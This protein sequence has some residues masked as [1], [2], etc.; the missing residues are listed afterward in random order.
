MS[1]TTRRQWLSVGANRRERRA[2]ASGRRPQRR[3]LRLE[4]LEDRRVLATFVVDLATDQDNGNTAAGDVSLRE[5]IV[6]ANTTPGP[7]TI[8]FAAGLSGQTLLLSGSSLPVTEALVIDGS[9]LAER[10]TIDAQSI[11]RVLDIGAGAGDVTL[12]NVALVN[13]R[14]ADATSSAEAGGSGGAVRSLS[15]GTLLLD[16]VSINGS[17][18]GDGYNVPY[19]PYTYGDGSDGGSGGAVFSVGNVV[20]TG[21]TI[22]GNRAG[23]GGEADSFYY[24]AGGVGGDGG[25]VFATGDVTI[26]SSSITGNTAGNG[27]ADPD[28]YGPTS[29]GDGGGV[30][31]GGTV[32]VTD[33]TI[34]GNAAGD[35]GNGPYAGDGGSGGAINAS[36]LLTVTRSTVAD[37]RAGDGGSRPEVLAGVA[38]GDG[39]DG[40]GLV[41]RAGLTM[42]D[43]TVSGN[44]SGHG[45]EADG[46]N[47]SGSGGDG[48]G[49]HVAGALDITQS[50]ISGNATGDGATLRNYSSGY[51][52]SYTNTA[53]GG[54][55][56]GGVFATSVGIIRQSTITGNSV[57]DGGAFY[58]T[59]GYAGPRGDGA[60]AAF[61][62]LSAAGTIEGTI[63]AGN[64]I[65]AG[66]KNLLA[67]D[68]FGE[69]NLIGPGDLPTPP[70]G[71]FNFPFTLTSNDPQIGP[72]K[73]NGGP[74]R[75]HSPL[76]GSPAIDAGDF[77]LVAPPTPLD[78]RGAGFPRLRG[79]VIDIGAVESAG[80]LVNDLGDADDGDAGNGVTTL[81][82]AIN[83]ANATSGF[84][85]IRFDDALLGETITLGSELQIT[86]SVEIDSRR[87]AAGVVT[88]DAAGSGRV[89]NIDDPT[90]TN[91]SFDVVLDD[92]IVTGGQTTGDNELVV[93]VGFET[94]H[95]GGAIRFMSSGTLSLQ[96]T[97]VTQSGT[98]GRNADGGGVFSATGTVE[99]LGGAITGNS[100]LGDGADGGGVYSGGDFVIGGE[101]GL[102]E[103]NSTA[104]VSADGGGVFSLTGKV[105]LGSALLRN[106]TTT[107][108]DSFG[109]GTFSYSGDITAIGSLITGNRTT[110]DGSWGGGVFSELGRVEIRDSTVSGNSTAGGGAYGGAIRT[111]FGDIVITGST[112]SGNTTTGAGAS[113][114]AIHTTAGSVQIVGSTIAENSVQGSGAVGGGVVMLGSGFSS[115]DSAESLAVSNT[116]VAK[117][118]A[119]GA[120]SDVEIA[121]GFST[122]VLY[123]LIGN[124]EGLTL[125]VGSVGGTTATPLD[126]RL[127]P[128]EDNG[129]PFLTHRPLIGS[130]LVDAG[131]PATFA[132]GGDQR[133]D[134]FPRVTDGDGDLAE[135]IDIGAVEAIGLVNPSFEAG[136]GSLAPWQLVNSGAATTTRA[137]SGVASAG[138][139]NNGQGFSV[140]LQNVPINGGETLLF[141]TQYLVAS[142]QP[143]DPAAVGEIKVEFYDAA[144]GFFQGPNF[145]GEVVAPTFDASTPTD[146][147]FYAEL[148]AAAPAEAV[149]ARVVVT[150]VGSDPGAVFY[151]SLALREALVVDSVADV[152]IADDGQTTLREAITL[153][154]TLPGRDAIAF[155]PNLSGQ[156]I[157]LAGS[158]ISITDSL[159]IA[160]D[161]VEAPV[162]IDAQQQSRVFSINDGD[163]AATI[164]VAI[165]DL[166]LTGGATNNQSGGAINTLENLTIERSVI[167]GN[168]TSGFGF[169]GGVFA[170][171]IGTLTVR[172]S[173][174]SGNTAYSGGALI[175]Y[176]TG[177]G[178]VVIESSTLSGNE[179]FGYTGGAIFNQSVLTIT[180]STI[181]DNIGDVGGIFSRFND[182]VNLSN[183]IIAGNRR[184]DGTPTNLANTGTLTG[185]QRFNVI[186]PG[187][188]M[189]MIDGV[190]GNQL[191]VADPLLGPL[192]PNGGP[193]PTHAPLAGS[194]AIDAGDPAV[195]AEPGVFDQRGEPFD[196]V[197]FGRIDVGAVEVQDPRPSQG[198]VVSTIDDASDGD[199]AVGELSLRE[200][201][202]IANLAPGPDTITFDPNVFAT[203]QTIALGSE[204]LVTGDTTITGP[205]ALLLVLDGQDATR[206]LHTNDGDDGVRK[207]VSISGL[208]ITRGRTTFIDGQVEPGRGG[209]L[210]NTEDLDLTDVV[211]SASTGS[212]GAGLWS[213]FG[214]LDIL[215]SQITGAV[216]GNK[217]GALYLRDADVTIRNSVVA[218]GQANRGGAAFTTGVNLTLEDSTLL[219]NSASQGSGLLRE[220]G[221]L[222]LQ[223]QTTIARSTITGGFAGRS[224]G[225]IFNRSG[226]L[227]LESSTINGGLA[228]RGG[229]LYNHAAATAVIQS[230]TL[231]G[232]NASNGGAIYNNGA[233]SLA[234]STVTDGGATTFGNAAGIANGQPG[235]TATLRDTIVSGN[236]DP[237]GPSN[238]RGVDFT[239]DYNLVGTGDAIVGVGNVASDSPGLAAL[240]NNGG[241]TQTHDFL[242]LSPA[243][244]AG[245]FR[246]LDDYTFNRFGVDY[247]FV[248]IFSAAQNTPSVVAG[249][250]RLDVGS[251]T[252][253]HI[254]DGGETL[255]AVGQFVSIDIGFNYPTTSS[256][257]FGSSTAGLGLFSTAT[258]GL[259]DEIR[260]NTSIASPGAFVFAT[261]DG[262]SS[263]VGTPTGLMTIVAEV[264]AASAGSL[265]LQYTLFGDGI[266]D[267]VRTETLS[268]SEIYFGPVAFN[269]EAHG[270]V[271][272]NLTFGLVGDVPEFD[273]RGDGFSRLGFGGSGQYLDIGAYEAQTAPVALL[274][275]GDFNGDGFVD[276]SDLN[277]LLANWGA[278]TVPPAWVNG[279][280]T[281]VDNGELN[282]LLANWGFGLSTSFATSGV[283]SAAAV[284]TPEQPVTVTKAAAAESQAISDAAFAT[285][286]SDSSLTIDGPK[287]S[288]S[289]EAAKEPAS[290]RS[291][292]TFRSA[293]TRLSDQRKDTTSRRETLSS[294]THRAALLLL[295]GSTPAGDI[296]ERFADSPAPS[297]GAEDFRED[298]GVDDET[299][300]SV[301][302]EF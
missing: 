198:L 46:A 61:T 191:G 155:A 36:G 75:T 146:T 92:L 284:P 48:G 287:S 176:T 73:N 161:T 214:T 141:S 208:T 163:G 229:A 98:T 14:A 156:T 206:V 87:T 174:I 63:I 220:G 263:L 56:G 210:R 299:L 177:G 249:Q 86:D 1:R 83:L 199:F 188:A 30:F 219:G 93:G 218:S 8:E 67:S 52:Y 96:E 194:P 288:S 184:T 150:Y 247:N 18:A 140:L 152:S 4:P 110:G 149:E 237:M 301:F 16:G 78:Q 154:N 77:E 259:I 227:T 224:G 71:S 28:E 167:T 172:D 285:L 88:I 268:V 12:R 22:S 202:E 10:P 147:W 295:V 15:T 242:P 165:T 187:G 143:R 99:L 23:D 157:A 74:T 230:S 135:R 89:F 158:E 39:G 261:F 181:T 19:V 45:G 252:G 84:A 294:Q 283:A 164:D 226:S 66:E 196:R 282:A 49:L 222:F 215:D 5:A 51:A 133:G 118:T 193:T 234:N 243:L 121:T 126:P 31:A 32:V 240:G 270:A 34:S 64:N 129:G 114:G 111:S 266:A 223:G 50:T 134:R 201:V 33:S 159:L 212:D 85:I 302:S 115:I 207:S 168:Q 6:L 81:R 26:T 190:D 21:S 113:G 47:T 280:D 221:A 297:L 9:A 139:A 257:S 35:G 267:V 138:L 7:D 38:I 225:A 278:S 42:T 192:Q 103:N 179:E 130:P 185:V 253:A 274:N 59:Y 264:T 182:V 119:G 145:L 3:R 286:A 300:D 101:G 281:F 13:G 216:A 97:I 166:T 211:I 260:L 256:G 273:Q 25:G 293:V 2:T 245:S 183:N 40:G 209:G 298:D 169:G 246:L 189:L 265:D 200:A 160:G 24:G 123:S 125:G 80:F 41:A 254:W 162:T 258:G 291:R 117:N 250:A 148:L 55:R 276:N 296:Q 195:L 128:L 79:G 228:D 112:V 262:D 186:G 37:N 120:S 62:Q 105:T 53:G 151:D 70:P 109:G 217:G 197:E 27:G 144:G 180:N 178:S 205:G 232:N 153:A 231:S 57:G 43:S 91:E 137:D 106:N 213:R 104:G 69:F 29:G 233:L 65:D 90:T 20:I 238:L 142:S 251:G 54:G 11:S 95:S 272:D 132:T 170:G 82:E 248:D 58:G 269:V 292:A 60:G 255:S 271:H 127:G 94:T 290:N 116:V 244:D 204:L 108:D 17:R 277:L 173:T 100:T 236:D 275:P 289:A 203:T 235:A 76:R 239:G 68:I 122:S 279:F 102:V 72:L 107:G 44:R 136:G 175:N 124:A 241:P 171:G 131:N